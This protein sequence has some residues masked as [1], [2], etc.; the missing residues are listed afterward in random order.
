[1]HGNKN[2]AKKE[3]IKRLIDVIFHAKKASI[4]WEAFFVIAYVLDFAAGS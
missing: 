4:Q 1:M 2:L 3:S